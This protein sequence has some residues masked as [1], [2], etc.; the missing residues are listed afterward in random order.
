MR[1]ESDAKAFIWNTILHPLPKIL[2]AML[3]EDLQRQYEVLIFSEVHFHSKGD[4][5]YFDLGLMLV[6]CP[7]PSDAPLANAQREIKILHPLVIIE[8]KRP[9]LAKPSEWTHKFDMPHVLTKEDGDPFVLLP[10]LL[11]ISIAFDACESL[12]KLGMLDPKLGFKDQVKF[13]PACLRRHV[14][15][16]RR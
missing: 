8:V 13:D 16:K 11:I 2:N 14:P 6:N 7:Q 3:R 10:Q 12:R 15:K 9:Y 4:N 1:N 5:S